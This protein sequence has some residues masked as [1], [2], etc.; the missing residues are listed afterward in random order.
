MSNCAIAI[1]EN[2]IHGH[3]F[4]HFKKYIQLVLI[5]VFALK[6]VVLLFLFCIIK[7]LC[8]LS[9][10]SCLGEMAN[11][12]SSMQVLPCSSRSTSILLLHFLFIDLAKFYLKLKVLTLYQE[13]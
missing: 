4:L 9:V 8:L 11:F 5:N 12:S 2:A 7:S 6:C 10:Q 13:G 3:S 1:L